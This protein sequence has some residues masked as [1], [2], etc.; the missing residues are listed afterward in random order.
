MSSD[1]LEIDLGYQR[2]IRK[3]LS[4]PG[5]H[6]ISPDEASSDLALGL[7]LDTFTT[8]VRYE[9][10]TESKH[11]I[12]FGSQWQYM[13]NER[14]GFEFLL[15]AF[16]SYQLGFFHYQLWPLSTRWKVNAGIRFDLGAHAVK[17]HLQ[18]IYDR[19]TLM[20][21]GDFEER[22]PK[23][24]RQYKNVSG[25]I[26]ATY[27]IN[28]HD[29]FKLHLGNSFRYPTAIELS[30]NGVHHGNFRHERGDANLGYRARISKRI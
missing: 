13:Q 3:E 10:N 26:G 6:G 2:N 23:F 4:F 22:T 5:A 8:N 27:K 19:S 15:P 12:L 14:D 24:D 11:Q 29:V 18:P 1:Q 9:V 16:N 20:P 7:Y 21:T 17:Q 25:A 28:S 30:S